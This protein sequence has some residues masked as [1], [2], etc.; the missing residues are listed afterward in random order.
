MRNVEPRAKVADEVR[1]L[2]R[3]GPQIMVNGNDPQTLAGIGGHSRQKMQHRDGI[4]AARNRQTEHRCPQLRSAGRR[5]SKARLQ[6]LTRRSQQPRIGL[7]TA[8]FGYW[9]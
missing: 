7:R 8:A 6:R 3:S 4:T 5:I 1:L 2:C 9:H